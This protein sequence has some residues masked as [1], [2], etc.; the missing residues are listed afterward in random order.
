[1]RT[2]FE[3]SA[4]NAEIA[5]WVADDPVR[6]ELLSRSN[7][8]MIRENTGNFRDLGPFGE[9]LAPEKA[10]SSLEFLSEFLTQRNSELFSRN[11]EF[12]GV[13]E[14]FLKRTGKPL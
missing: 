4:E 12:I 1:M 2:I 10:I 13:S 9:P 6:R 7:S 14:N 3:F 5:D 11:R 8:L